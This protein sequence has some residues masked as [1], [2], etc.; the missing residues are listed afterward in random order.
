MSGVGLTIPARR[1]RASS[2]SS[3]VTL[4]EI[5]A[6]TFFASA[7]PGCD[8]V[9]MLMRSE[10]SL[11][12]R[13][14]GIALEFDLDAFAASPIEI[15]QQ[16]ADRALLDRVDERGDLS[17]I[18]RVDRGGLGGV[19]MARG[20]ELARALLARKSQHAGPMRTLFLVDDQCASGVEQKMQFLCGNRV[21][22]ASILS[23]PARSASAR[24]CTSAG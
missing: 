13:A 3:I 20:D 22:A 18:G 17:R 15:E 23:R 19:E 14:E 5:V 7:S 8:S 12:R 10:V 4:S 24:S 6:L 9:L 1:S 2:R 11:A 16:V 21:Q